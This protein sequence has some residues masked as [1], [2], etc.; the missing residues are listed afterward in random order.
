MYLKI[1]SLYMRISSGAIEGKL[2]C[3]LISIPLTFF[4]M[5]LYVGGGTV[6]KIISP[7]LV[8]HVSLLFSSHCDQIDKMC[9]YSGR[10][11]A[12]QNSFL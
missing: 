11:F 1:C 4:L 5:S 8:S 12:T 6:T 9:M 3:F 10:L 7:H 2:H